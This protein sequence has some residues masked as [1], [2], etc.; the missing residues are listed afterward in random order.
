M[1]RTARFGKSRRC[2]ASKFSRLL[3]RVGVRWPPVPESRAGRRRPESRR[4]AGVSAG[5]AR[6]QAQTLLSICVRKRRLDHGGHASRSGVPRRRSSNP[7]LSPPPRLASPPTLTLGSSPL[8]AAGGAEGGLP[9]LHPFF[10]HRPPP[11]AQCC[12]AHGAI[13]KITF[14]SVGHPFADSIPWA[15]A[16]RLHPLGTR[17]PMNILLPPPTTANNTQAQ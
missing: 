15:P 6:V 4:P 16:R 14:L 3:C 17:S 1:G 9:N 12:R 7:L 11:E 5:A 8:C 2:P 10:T 13:R